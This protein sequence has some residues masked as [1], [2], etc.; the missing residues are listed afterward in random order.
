MCVH[1]W[2]GPDLVQG[3]I[4]EAKWVVPKTSTALN[5]SSTGTTG[6][7]PFSRVSSDIGEIFLI[8]WE[9]NWEMVYPRMEEN[10]AISYEIIKNKCIIFKFMVLSLSVCK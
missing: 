5:R 4:A 10:S 1:A 9:M 7:K 8:Q 6:I 3:E 2:E